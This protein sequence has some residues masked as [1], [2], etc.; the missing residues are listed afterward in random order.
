[1]VGS[2]LVDCLAGALD[3]RGNGADNGV[4][5]VLNLARDIADAVHGAAR[6]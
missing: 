3:E 4:N 1:M 2:A 6:G 5:A